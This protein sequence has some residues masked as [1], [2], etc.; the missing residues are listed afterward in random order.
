MDRDARLQN[1]D[2]NVESAAADTQPSGAA[3]GVNIEAQSVTKR[4]IKMTQK[5]LLEKVQTLQ[6]LRKCKL[7]K[8]SNVKTTI[9]ELM[10]ENEY[11]TEVR[12]AFNKYKTLCTE[13]KET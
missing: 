6:K 1:E 2:V 12:C 9:E 8:A 11:E 13:A 5:E 4:P 3:A 7:N 10:W